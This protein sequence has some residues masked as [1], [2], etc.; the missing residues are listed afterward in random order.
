M[1]TF[2]LLLLLTSLWLQASQEFKYIQPVAVEYAPSTTTKSKPLVRVPKITPPRVVK[3]K[4]V[5]PAKIAKQD[6][7]EDGIFDKNDNCED[8]PHNFSVDT[9][10]CPLTATLDVN[11][12]PASY[13][14][15]SDKRNSIKEFAKFLKK[16]RSYQVLI[17]GYADSIGPKEKNKILSR[18]RANSIKDALIQYGVSSTKLTVIG[19]GE[20]NPVATNMYKDGRKQNRRIE[21][22]LIK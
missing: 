14:I 16:N 3:E 17:Y 11:F 10:G 22:E 12:K 5:Q 18:N 8:T 15:V 6:S 21:I 9:Q 4:I 1:K 2:L 13:E 19:K 20:T 7:D